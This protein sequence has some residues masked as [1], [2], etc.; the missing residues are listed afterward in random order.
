M[1]AYTSKKEYPIKIA[2]HC[3]TAYFKCQGR[4][5]SLP[6]PPLSATATTHENFRTEAILFYATNLCL[7]GNRLIMNVLKPINSQIFWLAYNYWSVSYLNVDWSFSQWAKT[8]QNLPAA[9]SGF[10]IVEFRIKSGVRLFVFSGI[11]AEARAAVTRPDVRLH[12]EGTSAT[13]AEVELLKSTFT[14]LK[15]CAFRTRWAE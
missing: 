12:V 9:F 6:I 10:V 14:T 2:Q 1:R 5:F 7:A 3:F 15:K 11:M 4:R 8:L 13:E